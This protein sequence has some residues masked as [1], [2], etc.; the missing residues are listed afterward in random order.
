MG[1]CPE[2]RTS[3]HS[4]LILGGCLH[5]SSLLPQHSSALLH[6]LCLEQAK[7]E[8]AAF[9][10]GLFLQRRVHSLRPDS[11]LAVGGLADHRA[12]D[13]HRHGSSFLLLQS[14]KREDDEFEAVYDA[15][16]PV[17]EGEGD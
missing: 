11:I 3:T 14:G 4:R 8:H 2:Y 12:A 16:F 7:P 9:L 10:L 1:C 6:Y 5:P 13:R 17:S 15:A